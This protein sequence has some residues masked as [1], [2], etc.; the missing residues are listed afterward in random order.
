M[1]TSIYHKSKSVPALTSVARTGTGSP[2]AG[3]TVDRYTAGVTEYRTLM[4]VILAGTITD[5]TH[6]FAVQDSDDNSSWGTP[7]AGEVQGAAPV[8]DSTS[9][10]KVFDVG[11]SGA[12]RYAR[13][14]VTVATATTGGIYSAAAVLYGTRRD[15]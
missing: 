3:T 11:Y 12:K 8:L 14:Q 10:N 1:R 5:G 15:R 9:S 2:F 4:F 6:T 7:A 13:L